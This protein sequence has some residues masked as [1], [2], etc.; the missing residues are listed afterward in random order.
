MAMRWIVGV[1]VGVGMTAFC[2][3]PSAWAADGDTAEA[4]Q[5]GA[6]ELTHEQILQ[7]IEATRVT[8]PELAQEMERQLE[9]LDSG[10]LTVD[11]LERDRVLGA[12]AGEFPTGGELPM[13]GVIGL[14]VE[15][16]TTSQD[17]RV[18]EVQSDPRMQ[19]LREQFESGQLT[20]DQ[21]RERVFEV[22][23]DHGIEPA[24]G[25]EWDH[26]AGE[27][28]EHREEMERAW[29]QMAPEAR[30]QMER[31]FEHDGE[32]PE[33]ER[34]FGTPEREF[35]MPSHEYEAPMREYEAPM[36]EAPE[37]PSEMPEHDMEPPMPP[38]V[39]A[40]PQP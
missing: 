24:E 37:R 26:E 6:P 8:D 22:L 38:E 12:P 9:L 35:E 15:G 19:E 5:P 36:Y 28:L 32:R 4:A 27:S 10:E 39:Q 1:M 25:R 23:R 11:E 17:P 21:A 31:V 16:G 18:Q 3:M 40:P 33:M 30:E 20:E 2:V 29:E 34:E 13:P 7:D 14:P